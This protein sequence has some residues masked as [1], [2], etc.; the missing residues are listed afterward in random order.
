MVSGRG[1]AVPY[2]YDNLD[3][4]ASFARDHDIRVIG[5]TLVWYYTVPAWAKLAEPPAF[6]TALEAY[7]SKTVARFKNIVQ[8]WDVVNEPL[9]HRSMRED[10]L[11]ESAFLLK[12][13]PSYLATAFQTARAAAPQALLCLNE[14]GFEYNL[15][16][17]AR[18]RTDFIRLLRALRRDQV[19][20]DCIGLQSHL[21]AS[22]ELDI[23]G[24]AELMREIRALGF[25]IAITELDVNDRMLP[26]EIAQRDRLI[27]EHV[28][29]YLSCVLKDMRPVSIT[30]WGFTDGH[31]WLK[32][33]YK[34]ADGLPLRP[35]AF[36]DNF[37]RKPMWH[38]IDHFMGS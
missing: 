28:E 12:L 29:Q 19:P 22:K 4:I 14:Y 35:L 9:D 5:H 15:P 7:I 33:I 25:R 13:G 6:A 11:R 32:Y 18:K 24:L 23:Q 27:A 16:E 37:D 34:R 26:G 8:R 2:N 38:V 10:G 1:R 17:Q 31:S 20:V 3:V 36:D 30:T 21:D